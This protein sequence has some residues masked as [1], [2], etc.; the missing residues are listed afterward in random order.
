MSAEHPIS[1]F[2]NGPVKSHESVL[3]FNVVYCSTRTADACASFDGTGSR[4]VPWIHESWIRQLLSQY[5]PRLVP[6]ISVRSNLK[7]RPPTRQKFG[8]RRGPDRPKV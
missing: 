4:F 1:S 3:C 8:Q 7:F 2:G 5:A 6:T